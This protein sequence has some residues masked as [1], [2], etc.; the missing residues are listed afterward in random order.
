MIS[1]REKFLVHVMRI[2][3]A[4]ML[5]VGFELAYFVD[6]YIRSA[7]G[8]SQKAF[9]IAPDWSGLYYFT[10]RNVGLLVAFVA[11]WLI[12]LAAQGIYS[13]F[14]MRRLREINA[15]I[16]KGMI[17]ATL[18]TSAIAFLFKWQ[19]TSR[20]YLVTC[21]VV[22]MVILM[23]EKY[24]L[25]KFLDSVHR[26]GYNQ[27][28]L[29]IVGTGKRAREFIRA[30]K[31]NSHWGLRIVGLIDDEHGMFGK[32]VEGYRVLGRIQD[33]PFIL[34]RKVIDRVIFVVPRLWLHRIDEAIMACENL[35]I[36]TAVSLDLYNLKIAKIRQ[37][38]FN[39]FPLLEFETFRAKQWQLFI[40]RLLDIVLASLM[41][42]A[43]SPL[44]LVVAILIKLTSPGP[45]LFKQKRC[46]LNGRKF[47]LYKFR[48]MV[49][50]AERK[51][52]ELLR[53][54][55]MNGPVF[56]MKRD[57]RV[58]PIG[59]ILRKFSIDELPQLFNVLKGDMSI[60]GPRPALPVEVELYEV[61][62]RR[63]LSLKPGLTCIWQVS[64]RNKV[65]FERWMQMDLEYIDNWSLWLDFKIMLKTVF[66]VLTGYGAA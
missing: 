50:G 4:T 54:N 14:R 15:A 40:K 42:I 3:D 65:P 21:S 26:K 61:W 30:V 11:S 49:P 58:T 29:L 39:G 59:R 9:A 7:F 64:G 31:E 33:I 57:P 22:A 51:K 56:K 5:V 16:G 60:V 37:T 1:E 13:H 43:F 48:T 36:S 19:L 34:Q 41:L 63:R 28:N 53:M 35:G 18:S 46:G 66:V 52:Q 10:L 17:L 23:G 47:T 20:L 8:L 25:I 2:L 6:E 38:D 62:Q 12:L 44:M 55:E 24:L 27:I 45:V 32:E